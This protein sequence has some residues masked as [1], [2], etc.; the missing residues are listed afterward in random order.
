MF[1]VPASS[2]AWAR[3]QGTRGPVDRILIEV[4]GSVQAVGMLGVG[5]VDDIWQDYVDLRGLKE[6]NER[7]RGQVARYEEERARLIGVL[8]ENARLRQM[9]AFKDSRPDLKLRSA[10]IIGR[11][12]TPYFRVLR[13]RL[14]STNIDFTVK[15]Q[16]A[17]VSHQGVVGQVVEVY[18]DSADVLLV[19]DPRSKLD[20]MT[21]RNRAR[22]LVQGLG[23]SKDYEARVGYLRRK[24]EVAEG[25]QVVTSGKGGIFPQ[26]LLVGKITRVEKKAF[27][28]EQQAILEPTVDVGRLEEVFIITGDQTAGYRP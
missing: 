16:M 10:R 19:S 14:D 23:H 6:E 25:D 12:V 17:V 20:V 24:D 9:L 2:L 3:S 21:Q 15:P 1:A 18:G 5:F 7:L 27:G 4:M 22:G 8:Q 26:E 13:V 28:L 11:D